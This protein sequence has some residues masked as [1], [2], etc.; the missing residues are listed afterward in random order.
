MNRKLAAARWKEGEVSPRSQRWR[1]LTQ[2]PGTAKTRP[3]PLPSAHGRTAFACDDEPRRG[4]TPAI[5][6]RFLV[7]SRR[8]PEQS[9]RSADGVCSFHETRTREERR[10]NLY[11][12]NERENSNP[13]PRAA[14]RW[15]SQRPG[16]YARKLGIR[17]G[18]EA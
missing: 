3:R 9:F 8:P 7:E 12:P 4:V 16:R 15:L 13:P 11:S 6:P 17:Y 14:V 18:T 2:N 1:C 5:H 10:L